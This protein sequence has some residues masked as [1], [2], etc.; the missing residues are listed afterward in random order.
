[1]CLPWVVASVSCSPA[2]TLALRVCG[3]RRW[4]SRRGRVPGRAGGRSQGFC[5][6]D[7][8]SQQR[9]CPESISPT[10]A[11]PPPR[12]RGRQRKV[13]GAPRSKPSAVGV[14]L[15]DTCRGLIT[16]TGEGS[17]PRTR[18]VGSSGPTKLPVLPSDFCFCSPC[19]LA[20]LAPLSAAVSWERGLWTSLGSSPNQQKGQYLSP[21]SAA[22]IVPRGTPGRT[23]Q[24]LE[25]ELTVPRHKS[26]H[27]AAVQAFNIE[28]S[29][30]KMYF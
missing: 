26:T 8:R 11:R 5:T 10:R 18:P 9:G 12:G 3:V 1:M 25:L 19:P 21:P 22:A 29:L 28:K 16:A 15:L 6:R 23:F 27:T 4:P 13:M 7:P 2:G 20:F 30:S 17:A 24:D 14:Q